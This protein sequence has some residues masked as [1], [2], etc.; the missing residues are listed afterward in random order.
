V[1]FSKN[2]VDF[3]E[4]KIF[5]SHNFI[6]NKYLKNLE[7]VNSLF[8]FILLITVL[9]AGL[10]LFKKSKK[11]TFERFLFL[12][13]FFSFI[14]IISNYYFIGYLHSQKLFEAFANI[15][16]YIFY[17]FEIITLF[18]FYRDLNGKQKNIRNFII[19]AILSIIITI[20]L[21]ISSNIDPSFFTLTL[22][23]IFELFFINFSFSNFLIKNLEIEYVP[24][25][26]RLGII[27]YGLF[28]FINFTTPFYF[29]NIYLAKQNSEIPDLHF[30]T[31]LGYIIL[32]S[33]IIK[34]LRWKI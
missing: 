21:F 28:I 23:V 18:L 12:T 33:T 31:Y 34:S 9:V 26:T 29:I 1:F 11:S 17:L 24:A 27:N 4:Y 2:D 6:K 10:Q 14:D 8:K 5:D 20:S 30:I 15:N 13:I 7:T 25:I 22:I 3:T 16:Q 19:I 32:Y